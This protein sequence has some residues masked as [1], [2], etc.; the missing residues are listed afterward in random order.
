MG[1]IFAPLKKELW[2]SESVSYRYDAAS[3]AGTWQGTNGAQLFTPEAG[4]IVA[5]PEG[6]WVLTATNGGSRAWVGSSPVKDAGVKFSRPTQVKAWELL[7]SS[8]GDFSLSLGLLPTGQAEPTWV[9]PVKVLQDPET[10]VSFVDFGEIAPTTPSALLAAAAPYSPWPIGDISAKQAFWGG[11]T[12]GIVG[13]LL[14]QAAL[15]R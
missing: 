15:K 14:A 6:R 12:I 10:K 13:L 9:D 5:T 3:A 8:E 4:E 1:E 11:L 2:I 7:G